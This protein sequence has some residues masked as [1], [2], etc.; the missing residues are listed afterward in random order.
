[1][2]MIFF[3]ELQKAD[4]SGAWWSTL[5]S[6]DSE[7]RS[8]PSWSIEHVPGY[9]HREIPQKKKKKPQ[10]LKKERKSSILKFKWRH[11]SPM[12]Q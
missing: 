5:Y 7:E 2:Q 1:M 9:L 11:L 8:R 10:N 4:G 6:Q 3:T 12:S